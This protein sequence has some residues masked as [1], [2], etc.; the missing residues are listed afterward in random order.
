[1]KQKDQAMQNTM[2]KLKK[3]MNWTS[4]TEVSGTG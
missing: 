2:K 3:A 1:M 4:S